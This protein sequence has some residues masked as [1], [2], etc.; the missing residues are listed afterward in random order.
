MHYVM[1]KSNVS[2]NRDGNGID[3]PHN[4]FPNESPI[5]LEVFN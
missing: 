3:S 4:M 1:D 5:Q 2:E